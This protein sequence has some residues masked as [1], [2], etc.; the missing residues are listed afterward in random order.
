MRCFLRWLP[1]GFVSFIAGGLVHGASLSEALDSPALNWTTGGDAA[2]VVQGTNTH[3]GVDAAQAGAVTYGQQSRLSAPVVGPGTMVFWAS[4]ETIGATELSAGYDGYFILSVYEQRP[5]VGRGWHVYAVDVPAG[6]HDLTFNWR[7]YATDAAAAS[8]QRAWVDQLAF[9]DYSGQSPAFVVDVPDLEL[10]EE[11]PWV[12]GAAVTGALPMGATL[13]HLGSTYTA[14]ARNVSFVEVGVTDRARA[15]LNGLWQLVVTNNLGA[16]TSRTFSVT[17]KPS[18]PL[19]LAAGPYSTDVGLGGPLELSGLAVGTEPLTYRW[20]HEG[21]DLAGQNQRVLQLAS[22]VPSD[23][24]QYRFIVTNAYGSATSQVAVVTLSTVPPTITEQPPSQ[25]VRP[26]DE[27]SIWVRYTGSPPFT[28]QWQKDGVDLP[29]GT[30]WSYWIPSATTADAGTYRVVVRNRFGS[31]TSDPATLAV[32]DPL[33]VALDAPDLVFDPTNADAPWEVVTDVTHDGTDALRSGA[34]GNNETTGV[35]TELIGPGTLGFWW[36]VSSQPDADQME[37]QVDG[38]VRSSIS[39]DVDWKHETFALEPG[40][41]QVLWSYRKDGAEAGGLDAAW[42]DEVTWVPAGPIPLPE[43]LEAPDQTFE[44]GGA[45]PWTGQNW[46]THDGVDAAQSGSIREGETSTMSL[47][48]EGPGRLEYWCRLAAG[49]SDRLRISLDGS[50]LETFTGAS[51]WSARTHAIGAG[52]HTLTWSFERVEWGPS[53]TNA[54]WID[55][56]NWMPYRL[57]EALDAPDLTFN[58]DESAPWFIETG[59]T[60]DGV[61]AL[62][63]T[64]SPVNVLSLLTATITGPGTLSFWGKV[65]AGPGSL[66]GFYHDSG[67]RTL[68]MGE[69]DWKQFGYEIKPGVQVVGWAFLRTTDEVAGLNA[70]FLDQVSFTPRSAPTISVPPQPVKLLKGRAFELM[71]TAVGQS[72]LTYQW[73][74]DGTNL[75]GATAT[76]LVRDVATY[77]DTGNYSV[78]V[79]NTLGAVTSTVARVAVVPTFYR[80]QNLGTLGTGGATSEAFDLNNHG[81]IVGGA[82]TD[83]TKSYGNR[84]G[85]G[86]VWTP[87]T[88]LRDLG[89]GRVAINVAATNRLPGHSYA[90]AIND[91]FDIVGWFEYRVNAAFDGRAHAAYWRQTNCIPGQP[92]LNESRCALELVD[93]HPGN[94]TPRT[95]VAVDVN[96]RRLMVLQEGIDIVLEHGG[97]LLIPQDSRDRFSPFTARWIGPSAGGHIDPAHLNNAGVV[98]GRYREF[99]GGDQP[100]LYDGVWHAGSDAMPNPVPGLISWRRFQAISDRGVIAGLYAT[101]SPS[102]QQAHVFVQQP[103]GSSAP[104][105]DPFVSISRLNA[106]N[107]RGQMVGTEYANR[108]VLFSDGAWF[109]LADLL[110][111]ETGASILTANAIN[112]GGQ[113]VGQAVFPLVGARAYLLTPDV[114]GNHDPVARDDAFEVPRDRPSII[115]SRALLANDSDADADRLQVEAVLGNG[116]QDQTAAGGHVSRNGDTIL[117]T[118]PMTGVAEDQFE[119]HIGDQ[120]GGSARARVTLTL[121][122]DS[123]AIPVLINPPQITPDGRV[124]LSGQA[125]PGSVVTIYNMTALEDASPLRAAVLE[126]D[127]T[128]HWSILLPSTEG[129]RRRFYSVDV[130]V[131]L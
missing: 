11:H 98:V 102:G 116:N 88:G 128:A 13:R 118:P 39:G 28:F 34:I 46:I 97:L 4:V 10:P 89:D 120:A 67:F 90:Y 68:L 40:P 113:I 3:D 111:N 106:I 16:V 41:H 52:S 59:V 108:A 33:A 69:S 48:V 36:K 79:T 126:V 58:V 22:T 20:Q 80:I 101:N 43:A 9:A 18:P 81:E 73:L 27:A 31:V 86:F 104:V 24:G 83:E 92:P 64:A 38:V 6:K 65:S 2:W 124:L 72:P 8:G 114:P 42:L 54:A 17:V 107:N 119:Y 66:L 57:G 51:D 15:D 62:Q 103:D 44:V 47:T 85:H 82:E 7:T 91:Q 109:I 32:V 131:P 100:Y 93:V 26:G 99:I 123:A 60:H 96:E 84:L 115:P 70:A 121:V 45:A 117:Y 23:A 130:Q 127:A 61:D 77:G 94:D 76:N 30:N 50:V 95:T 21:V 19:I 1:A 78:L 49:E 56:V 129:S 75:P 53:G 5:S 87:D 29:E 12:L 74:K 71:V 37:F 35:I 25:T 55:Q 110:V 125:P 105:P 14:P 63:S 112:D 122:P